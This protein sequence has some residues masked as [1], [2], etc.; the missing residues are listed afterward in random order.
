MYDT[1]SAMKDIFARYIGQQIGLNL[2]E[3]GKF[4]SITLV[5]VQDSYFSVR[6]SKGDAIAHYPF[7][8]VL[9]FTESQQGIEIS[10]FGILHAPKV[11][12]VVQTYAL[13]GGSIGFIFPI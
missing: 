9:S 10:G 3:I 2:K 5:D 8:Q 13:S 11:H 6:G 1:L 7:R 12:F 4:H